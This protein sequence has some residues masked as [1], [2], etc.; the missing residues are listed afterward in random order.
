MEMQRIP[1]AFNLPLITEGFR[2][3]GKVSA[4]TPHGSGHIHD[5]FLVRT[6]S[7]SGPDYLLQ[8]INNYV[9]KDVE[10]LM[11]NIVR[12]TTFLRQ[13]LEATPGA[14]PDRE[15]LTPVQTLDNKYYLQDEAG[16]YWRMFLFIW[17]TKSYDVVET[18]EQAFEGQSR[19]LRC[20]GQ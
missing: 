19:A 12:I 10:A 4:I 5:T 8:R 20:P 2:I 13:K 3:K 11:D 18:P 9:F 15:T 1:E 17:G 6:A 7:P 16:N 14:D